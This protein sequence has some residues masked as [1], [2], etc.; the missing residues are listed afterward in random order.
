MPSLV[1]G[2]AE[3]IISFV[4]ANLDKE[5]F[6]SILIIVGFEKDS[7]FKV[8]GIEVKYLN[9]SRVLSA[10]P[11]LYS[12]LKNLKP[13]LVVSSIFHLNIVSG[14]ISIF[15][16]KTKFIAREATILGSRQ[17]KKPLIASLVKKCYRRFDAIICQSEDMA[18]DLQKNYN[19]KT[20]RLVVINNP[21]TK[22]LPFKEKISN[23]GVLKLITVGRLEKVK[24]H[25]R[26]LRVLSK[27]ESPFSYT[28]IGEGS[29]KDEII[30]EAKKLGLYEKITFIAYTSDVLD[31]LL[32]HDLYLQGSYVEGFPNALLESCSTGTPVIAFEAPGGTKEIIENGVNGFLV[33]DE[34]EFLRKLN[35]KHTWISSDV[36]ES[37]ITKF[38]ATEILKKY[39]TLFAK[40]INPL[41]D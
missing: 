32:A 27:L 39:E 28:I 22:I 34:K 23:D 33:K 1:A 2:G 41:S 10:I 24:G 19:L 18:S 26:L 25:L 5:R 38:S 4:S 20:R 11:K 15:F 16:P 37:V 30:V 9:E 31:F 7:K 3:R 35:S 21:I 13:D 6:N 36:R 14:A 12:N 8:E 17:N 40:T 29:L